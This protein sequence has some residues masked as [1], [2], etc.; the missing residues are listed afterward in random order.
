MRD[1]EI[2]VDHI[3]AMQHG[4]GVGSFGRD[5]IENMG[6]PG[7]AYPIVN[8]R[9]EAVYSKDECGIIADEIQKG[10]LGSYVSVA[11]AVVDRAKKN[12]ELNGAV[13]GVVIQHENGLYAK[14]YKTDNFCAP[15]IDIFQENNVPILSILHTVEL[16][17]DDLKL[18]AHMDNVL[19]SVVSGSNK[20]VCISKSVIQQMID[21]YGIHRGGMIYI[22]HGVPELTTLG[23]P[24][25]IRARY[26]FRSDDTIFTS[27][28]HLSRGKGLEYVIDGL[29]GVAN[30]PYKDQRPKYFIAGGTHPTILKNEGEVYREFLESKVRDNGLRGA[31][32]D[33]S[34]IIFD[35]YGNKLDNIDDA[36][37]VFLKRPL[38]D[39]EIPE[40][41]EMSD[42]GAVFNL[43]PKQY[44]SGPGSQWTGLGKPVIATE[45]IFFKDL[46][47]Q[48]I[49]LLVPFRN[50]PAITRVMNDY[51]V[52]GPEGKE[53]L[54]FDASDKGSTMAWSVVGLQYKNL[55]RNLI[56]HNLMKNKII[57]R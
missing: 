44:S 4:C 55:I 52:L 33:G 35:M 56:R 28:G 36:D 50:S 10:D 6:C 17:N 20:S 45:S 27:F 7:K 51:L 34:D 26:G 57:G 49:G 8:D 48:G 24:E 1:R 15:M 2:Y 18:E 43:N 11:N 19:R 22:P 39:E 53:E 41:I 37:V 42:V 40:I 16:S 47:S 13:T 21:K 14:N 54:A 30:G 12:Y 38:T 29:P 23:S 5:A 31:V 9:G 46:Q 25:E 32:M 3:G